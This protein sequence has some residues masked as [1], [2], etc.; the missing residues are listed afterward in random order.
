M[1]I[2][3]GFHATSANPRELDPSSIAV[4][5]GFFFLPKN[6]FRFFLTGFKGLGCH[7]CA[8]CKAL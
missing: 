6:G 8:A 1:V 3:C 4:L 7:N 5:E 2:F